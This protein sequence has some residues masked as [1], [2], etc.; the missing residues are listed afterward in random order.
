[1][2][3]EMW[4]LAGSYCSP[5]PKRKQYNFKNLLKNFKIKVEKM[6][7]KN[8]FKIFQHLNYTTNKNYLSA[9]INDSDNK[10]IFFQYIIEDDIEEMFKFSFDNIYH[11]KDNIIKIIDQDNEVYSF[12]FS[13]PNNIS[14]SEE[15]FYFYNKKKLQS[16]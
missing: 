13:L 9:I 14:L 11:I 4:D 7:Q 5:E 16:F 6:A 8:D 12:K 10:L 1:M 3:D 2:R 15:I